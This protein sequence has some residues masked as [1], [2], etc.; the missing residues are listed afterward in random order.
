MDRIIGGSPLGVLL[1]LIILSVIVGVVLTALDITPADVLAGVER[2]ANWIYS[3]GFESLDTVWGYFIIG[4]AVVIPIWIIYRV[5]KVLSS[6]GDK[7][8]N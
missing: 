6:S 4:A 8:A 1:R 5:L 3:L 2:L 7:K